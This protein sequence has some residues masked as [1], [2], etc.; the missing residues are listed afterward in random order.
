MACTYVGELSMV[1]ELWLE[2]RWSCKIVGLA[3]SFPARFPAVGV[4]SSQLDYVYV[5]L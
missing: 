3:H 2:M 5:T 1:D 4:V